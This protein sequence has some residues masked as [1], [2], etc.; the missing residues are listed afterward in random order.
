M[1]SQE[2]KTKRTLIEMAI[3]T[4]MTLMVIG[5]DE[6][7]KKESVVAV[8]LKTIME[9]KGTSLGSQD[10]AEVN[11]KKHHTGVVS[12]QEMKVTLQDTSLRV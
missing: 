2:A 11:G 12:L 6:N 8:D 5:K 7:M 1:L 9:I 10:L 4:E 3:D